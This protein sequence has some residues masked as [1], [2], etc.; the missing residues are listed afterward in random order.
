VYYT[1]RGMVSLIFLSLNLCLEIMDH[2]IVWDG[3]G[4][5]L[6]FGDLGCDVLTN[7]E[8][9]AQHQYVLLMI[10]RAWMLSSFTVLNLA[11]HVSY[12]KEFCWS[13][14]VVSNIWNENKHN[15]KD[16]LRTVLQEYDCVLRRRIVY[17]HWS[18]FYVLYRYYCIALAFKL[19]YCVRYVWSVLPTDLTRY[20]RTIYRTELW[21]FSR[22]AMSSL[23]S[24]W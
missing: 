11:V 9:C 22:S 14:P 19:L 5:M 6:I 17:L 13:L 24:R 2:S 16:K 20:G 8:F 7:G 18:L 4:A 1:R 12:K 10:F 23:R 3:D 15:V 21:I